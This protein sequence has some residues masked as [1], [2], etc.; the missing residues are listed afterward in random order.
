MAQYIELGLD[1]FGDIQA[2][3]NGELLSHAQV[4]RNVIDESV[5]ADE[6]GVYLHR[7]R[8]ASSGGFC[9]FLPRGAARRDR[10]AYQAHSSRLVGYR[11]LVR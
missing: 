2:G 4:I 3:L 6:V 5:L 9:Y 7:S 8:R 11:A 10:L 1:T